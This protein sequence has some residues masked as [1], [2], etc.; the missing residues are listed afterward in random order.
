MGKLQS[1]K[2]GRAALIL[3]L[4]QRAKSGKQ[5]HI[6]QWRAFVVGFVA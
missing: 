2:T 6:H 1:L 4:L 5:V 3:V